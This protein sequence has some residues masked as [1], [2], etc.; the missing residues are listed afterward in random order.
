MEERTVKLHVLSYVKKNRFYL[1]CLETDIMTVAD[2]FEE[3]KNKMQDA[4]LS[5]FKTFTLKELEADKYIRKAPLKYRIMTLLLKFDIHFESASKIN[6][7]YNI[8]GKELS[9]A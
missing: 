7:N 1:I 2:S 8:R 4:L 9:F 3:G 6:R 5:Y